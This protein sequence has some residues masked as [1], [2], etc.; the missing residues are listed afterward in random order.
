MYQ[1]GFTEHLL[2]MKE[3]RWDRV[4]HPTTINARELPYEENDDRALR[5][6]NPAGDFTISLPT[7][8]IVILYSATP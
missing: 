3:P 7:D 1:A 6:R 4:N 2:L 8:A 5:L